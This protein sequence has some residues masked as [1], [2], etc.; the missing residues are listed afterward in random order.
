MNAGKSIVNWPIIIPLNLI[1]GK[2][3]KEAID[4]ARRQVSRM[5]GANTEGICSLTLDK[6]SISHCHNLQSISFVI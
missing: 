2:A 6:R 1:S 5:I 4:N 3:A